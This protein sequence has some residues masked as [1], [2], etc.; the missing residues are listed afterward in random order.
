MK[1]LLSESFFERAK[2]IVPGGVHSPVRA[3]RGVGGV[4]RFIR[5]ASGAELE[6]VDGNRYID[7]CMSWGPL[8]LGHQDPDVLEEVQVALSRGW[9]YGTVEPYSLDLAELITQNIPWMKKIRFVNSGT[10]AVMAALRLAR[11]ATGRNKILKFDGCYHGHVDSMLVRAGSGLAEMASPDSAGVTNTVASD[12]IVIPLNDLSALEQS[13]ELYGKEIAA[14]IVEPVPANN[15]LLIQTESFLSKVEEVSKRSG[16]LLI[17]DEVITGFRIAFGG[18]AE[19]TGIQPDL[20]TYGKIIGGGFP[21]GAYGGR[22]DLM[23]LIAPMGPVYQAGT[24]S[25]NP[26]AMTA[27]LATLRKLKKENPY[28]DL[29][30]KV[31]SLTQSIESMAYELDF[32]IQ[33]QSEASLFW[34]LFGQISTPDGKVRNPVDAPSKHKT[35]YSK[36]FHSLLEKGIYLAPSA[37]EVSFLSTAHQ[38]SHLDRLVEALKDTILELREG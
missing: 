21:V 18:M 4:P 3:F 11:A 19:K 26:I 36:A 10:E 24:L 28:S 5:S 33:A 35:Y 32:P 30:M 14:V 23:D 7:F 25:A 1:T 27:G 6:D 38:Q 13:F 22:A 37:F 8:I 2:K 34:T 17:F 12:T 29:E 9:S 15:G 16:S 20:I 31:K